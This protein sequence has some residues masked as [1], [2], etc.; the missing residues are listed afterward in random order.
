MK[1]RNGLKTNK[2]CIFLFVMVL[3]GS[4]F[5][6]NENNLQKNINEKNI[7]KNNLNISGPPKNIVLTITNTMPYSAKLNWDLSSVVNFYMVQYVIVYRN[8][9][10]QG[11]VQAGVVLKT[12]TEFLDT[13]LEP[14]LYEYKVITGAHSVEMDV[15]N[16]V[17]F[18]LNNAGEIEIEGVFEIDIDLIVMI[19]FIG[20]V[21]ISGI[22]LIKYII[23]NIKRN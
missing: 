1:K 11:F 9:N 3:M 10:K 6:F 2:I 21:I 5:I 14:G 7:N 13:N 18:T 8:F 20:I 16:I 23:K 12:H 4:V 17:K 19:I 22:F 15:S